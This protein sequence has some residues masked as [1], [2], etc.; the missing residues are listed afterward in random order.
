M[1]PPSATADPGFVDVAFT[2]EPNYDGWRLDRYLCEKIRRL[3][4][5]RVQVI[6]ARSLVADRPLKPSTR[7][8]PGLT[9]TLRRRAQVEPEVPEGI[10]ELHLDPHLLVLDKP[11]GLPIHPTARYH[12]NT[13]VK[14]LERKHG[15]GLR[16]DP[17]HRLDRETSGLLVC[18]RGAEA[19]RALMRAF[20]SGQVHKEY[21]A[22]LEGHPP[23][24]VV[25]DAP[26]AEGT[27]QVRIAVRIDPRAGKPA[28]TRFRV[29]ERFVHEGAPFARVRCFPETG[30]QHQIRIHA[31]EA[32]FPLV[33]DKIYGPDPGY[34]DRFSKRCLEPEAWARLRLPRH[35]LHAARLAFPHP[36]TGDSLVFESPLPP[37]L[38]NFC[39]AGSGSGEVG[40]G[41]TSPLLNAA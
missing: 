3:S 8:H 21:L 29:E 23:D 26:I 2:V 4:R 41:V 13:L 12:H 33:G 22:I 30:R 19:S 18:G 6:I 40:A 25:V 37:D 38:L 10:V 20:Q 17:A 31:R 1:S 28:R 27:A 15:P 34:F 39:R 11:A 5:T 9:F 36:A 16:A 14:L 35:A 7:V 24:E 32:G